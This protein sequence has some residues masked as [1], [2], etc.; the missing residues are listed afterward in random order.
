MQAIFTSSHETFQ[1][2]KVIHQI[3]ML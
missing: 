1:T 2:Q 3:I